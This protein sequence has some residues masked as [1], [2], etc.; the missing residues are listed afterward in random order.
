MC[1]YRKHIDS[2]RD[3][4]RDGF[5]CKH[6]LHVFESQGT[7]AYHM[8]TEHKITQLD[9]FCCP[10]CGQTFQSEKGLNAHV[11]E[12]HTIQKRL[13]LP[14][15]S[16]F[17]LGA[18]SSMARQSGF[19]GSKSQTTFVDDSLIHSPKKRLDDIHEARSSGS[20]YK[21][22][23]LSK[24]SSYS[25]ISHARLSRSRDSKARISRARMSK[26][27]QRDKEEMTNAE[28]NR[29]QMAFL[30]VNVTL[31]FCYYF[32]NHNIG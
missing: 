27:F 1:V 30:Q 25:R 22:P 14:W 24:A 4:E 5:K 26:L 13:I 10:K 15:E 19:M 2:H 32:L 9:I 29:L 28:F 7:F 12:Y 17:S 16:N 20:T 11:D 21:K 6:C 23:N 8:K 3:T 18:R 31:Y